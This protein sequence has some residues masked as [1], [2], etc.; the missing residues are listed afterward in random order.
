MALQQWV[1]RR[2]KNR[3]DR[4]YIEV[5]K[6][7]PDLATAG[8]EELLKRRERLVRVRERAFTD[9]VAERLEAD[10]SFVILQNHI[11]SELAS[12]QRRLGRFAH[13]DPEAG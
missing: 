5:V 1:R 9:L 10:E 12:I 2:R 3:V 11:D 13:S 4:Y 8:S 7:A 6:G